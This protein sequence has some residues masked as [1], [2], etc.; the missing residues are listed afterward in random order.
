MLPVIMI[1]GTGY[2]VYYTI[3]GFWVIVFIVLLCCRT[4][5]PPPPPPPPQQDIETGHIPAI[6]KTTVETI[7]KVEDVEEGDEG[8]CSICLE[9]FKI[10]H[11]LM[12]IK[13]CR[14]VFH[15]FCILSWIDANRNCPIC[16]CSVD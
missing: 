15:R 14:H 5:P 4:P 11:E 6:N 7:I 2:I 9:E 12:C 13:K 10:G 3:V 1:I 16:R 8:C